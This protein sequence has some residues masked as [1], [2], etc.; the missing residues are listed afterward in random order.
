MSKVES[1]G[2]RRRADRMAVVFA[3]KERHKIKEIC[4]NC[5]CAW[6]RTIGHIGPLGPMKREC[7]NCGGRWM[8]DNAIYGIKLEAADA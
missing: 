4:P 6:F 1:V 7:K 3:F 5:W 2:Q 8:D